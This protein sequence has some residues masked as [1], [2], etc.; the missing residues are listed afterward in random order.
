MPGLLNKPASSSSRD[1]YRLHKL[2]LSAPLAAVVDNLRLPSWTPPS[3]P[4]LDANGQTNS[5]SAINAL[6]PDGR[7]LLAAASTAPGRDL[8]FRLA[9]FCLLLE[10]GANPFGR[11]RDGRTVEEVWDGLAKDPDGEERGI[12]RDE[13][14]RAR[15]MWAEGRRYEKA[16]DIEEWIQQELWVLEEERKRM[17]Q[18]DPVLRRDVVQSP[19]PMSAARERQFEEI[20]DPRRKKRPRI[21]DEFLMDYEE[22]G[23]PGLVEKKPLRD[24]PL[25]AFR[26]G[27][28]QPP[29]P[30][31][32]QYAK[33]QVPPPPPPPPPAA[34]SPPPAPVEQPPTVSA[35]SR[36]PPLPPA[37]YPTAASRLPPPPRLPAATAAPPPSAPPAPQAVQPP[38]PPPA[39][40]SRNRLPP[41]PSQT[42][43]PG[44]Q[45]A[46]PALKPQ[47][48]VDANLPAKPAPFA[49]SAQPVKPSRDRLPPAGATPGIAAPS[50]VNASAQAAASAPQPEAAP[51]VSAAVPGFSRNR[52]PKPPTAPAPAAPPP[53][54]HEADRPSAQQPRSQ[55]TAP[56]QQ[57]PQ[58]TEASTAE[59]PPAPIPS[60]NRLPPSVGSGVAAKPSNA[61]QQASAGQAV[62]PSVVPA[63]TLPPVPSTSISPAPASQPPAST[64]PRAVVVDDPVTTFSHPVAATAASVQNP[65]ERKPTPAE[66]AAARSAMVGKPGSDNTSRPSSPLTSLPASRQPS[67]ASP[68]GVPPAAEAGSSSSSL[69]PLPSSR[70]SSAASIGR[71]KS[72]AAVGPGGARKS[73]LP[74]GFAKK[75]LS[76]VNAAGGT[77]SSASPAPEPGA[78]GVKREASVDVPPQ[79][80]PAPTAGAAS[81][82]PSAGNGGATSP[83]LQG[84]PD[85]HSQK[86]AADD[87][88]VASPQRAKGAA[89]PG[90]SASRLPPHGG[91]AV[92]PLLNAANPSPPKPLRIPTGGTLPAK[93]SQHK[94]SPPTVPQPL[95]NPLT[96]NVTGSNIFSSASAAPPSPAPSLAAR[97]AGLPGRPGGLA[98]ATGAPPTEPRALREAREAAARGNGSPS[99]TKQASTSSAAANAGPSAVSPVQARRRRSTSRPTPSGQTT[100]ELYRVPAWATETLLRHWL[101]Q[102]PDV[103]ASAQKHVLPFLEQVIA[104]NVFQP[105][106]NPP[107]PIPVKVEVIDRMPQG[108]PVSAGY[109]AAKVTY[110]SEGLA[111]RAKEICNGRRV[112]GCD[113]GLGVQ[114]REANKETNAFRDANPR[115]AGR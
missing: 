28:P 90:S 61:A 24:V 43:L 8:A 78:G 17:M 56:S 105:P 33:R 112:A 72:A 87:Q 82:A 94:P 6:T 93:P 4:T 108:T 104:G 100:M 19:E 34:P 73:R 29:P 38:P 69:T 59:K 12:F 106:S 45:P 81:P 57:L 2:F 102:G 88:Q 20:E 103:F 37:P 39:G 13:L 86:P 11:G 58:A 71:P 96:A 89:P 55:P 65:V 84:E 30:P 107:P 15:E 46:A 44:A 79:Q 41:P 49:P 47:V 42:S 95:H 109:V 21:V 75:R 52:L 3:T 111:S 91:A 64:L 60:R 76:G 26:A 18:V 5:L 10:R 48:P 14:A 85:P 36:L 70:P 54:A 77:G 25:D 23:D 68:G 98:A 67:V 97:P 9:C 101:V 40:P 50:T 53:A 16:W 99:P 66:L 113:E 22:T 74:P 27:P 115:P 110:A 63:Q 7:T 92:P 62:P 114:W 31:V 83:A 80:A 1:S 35:A 51:S 32:Q